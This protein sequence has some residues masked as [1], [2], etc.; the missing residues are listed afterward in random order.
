MR[1]CS[2]R[3]GD[4]ASINLERL[5]TRKAP[6][7]MDAKQLRS[8]GHDLVDR[9]ADFLDSMRGHPVTRAE[10]AEEVRAAVTANRVLPEE[11]QDP[12][13]L[14]RNTAALLFEHSLFNG[15]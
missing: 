1:R 6:L 12:E 10:S 14:L 8:L 15:H 11:G 3:Y 5:R 7:E 4:M 2:K 9:V 13:S